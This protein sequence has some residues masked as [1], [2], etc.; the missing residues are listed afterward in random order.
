MVLFD[1][2]N[3]NRTPG[4]STVIRPPGCPQ[5]PKWAA[6]EFH[7]QAFIRAALT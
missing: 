7:E 5:S 1:E 6:A 3:Q 4:S 2:L